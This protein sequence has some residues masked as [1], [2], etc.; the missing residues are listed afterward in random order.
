MHSDVVPEGKLELVRPRQRRSSPL[1]ELLF[2]S[3]NDTPRS[4]EQ[5]AAICYR[6]RKSKIEFLL[7]QT[8]KG[9]WIFPK[10]GI[11]RG[12]TRA[13]S[14][15]LEAF[16]EGGVHGRIEEAS[17]TRYV[18]R[19]RGGPE[20]DVVT[21]AFLCEVLRLESPQEPNRRP[22]WF[23]PEKAQLRLKEQRTRE[24]G[25]ELARVVDR[26]KTRIER[27]ADENSINTEPLRRVQFEASRMDARGLV[28][29]FA[30]LSTLGEKPRDESGRI[31]EFDGG[32]R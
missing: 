10:G 14:A 32:T 22:T 21:H 30:I 25:A 23:S 4:R 7:V 2:S 31:I 19:K 3:F 1:T 27:L 20:S 17:F 29:R 11:V 18:L 12:C 8:R 5:V 26:A 28:A 9:R 6:I 24:N 13:Q 15:A 16:E